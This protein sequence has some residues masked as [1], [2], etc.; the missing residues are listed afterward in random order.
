MGNGE[1]LIAGVS[2]LLPLYIF[3]EKIHIR[4]S[5]IMLMRLK[6]LFVSILI[7][8]LFF[9]PGQLLWPNIIWSPTFEGLTQGLLR[10]AVLVLLVAAVNFLLSSTEQDDFLSAVLWC[11][12]PLSIVGLPH[13]RLAV[14]ITLTLDE[15]SQIRNHH[16]YENGN[17]TKQDKTDVVASNAK[18]REPKLI[19]IART[20]N[21][22]FQTVIRNAEASPVREIAIPEETSPPIHQWSIPALLIAIFTVIKFVEFTNFSI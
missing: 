2:L 7:V 4:T 21:H 18:K 16:V 8:Y 5:L 22:Y 6:W 10:I 3:G 19:A 1:V 11:L 17:I 14:R 20:A 15:V 9:T 13:E 12:R